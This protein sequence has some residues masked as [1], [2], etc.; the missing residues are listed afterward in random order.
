MGTTKFDET[1]WVGGH[2]TFGAHEV[3]GL[4]WTKAPFSKNCLLLQGNIKSTKLI[5]QY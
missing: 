1:W 4:I 5:T 2:G 3:G